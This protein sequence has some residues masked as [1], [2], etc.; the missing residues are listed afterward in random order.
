MLNVSS[1]TSNRTLLLV[2]Y[3]RVIYVCFSYEIEMSQCLIIQCTAFREL[4]AFR[5]FYYTYLT[6]CFKCSFINMEYCLLFKNKC[7]PNLLIL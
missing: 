4:F 7:L 2:M 6:L 3:L 5:E 1:V